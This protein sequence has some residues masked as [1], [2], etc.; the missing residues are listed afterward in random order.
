MRVPWITY[1]ICPASSSRCADFREPGF[2]DDPRVPDAIKASV[3]RVVVGRDE[4][5]RAGTGW[6][7]NDAKV[8]KFVPVH[9]PG[10]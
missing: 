2:L 6:D 8:V 5:T 3:G 10:R 9:R 4:D 1:A 7:M